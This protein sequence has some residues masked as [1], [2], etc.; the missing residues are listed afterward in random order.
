MQSLDC[1]V[2]PKNRTAVFRC[3][4]RLRETLDSGVDADAETATGE[5]ENRLAGVWTDGWVVLRHV[6][7]RHR[8]APAAAAAAGCRSQAG[9][10][11][12]QDCAV[13]FVTAAPVVR[14][15]T[16]SSGSDARA[17]EERVCKEGMG[18]LQRSLSPGSVVP[19]LG[20]GDS[21]RL[22]HQGT[23]LPLGPWIWQGGGM[24][25]GTALIEM[26]KGPEASRE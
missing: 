1:L 16:R 26:L 12:R 24:G 4:S 2:P 25:Q 15:P 21:D 11:A 19:M 23:P 9:S 5:S 14:D 3:H 7:Q 8:A 22:R 20:P 18:R 13:L 10:K 17:R 6:S